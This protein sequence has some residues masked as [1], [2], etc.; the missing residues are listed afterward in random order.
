M[1]DKER[2]QP[3]KPPAELFLTSMRILAPVFYV[4]M[5]TIGMRPAETGGILTS[6]SH[7]YVITGFVFDSHG[8]RTGTTYQPDTRYLNQFLVGRDSEYVGTVHSHP[9]DFLEP[10]PQDQRAAWSNLTSPGNPHLQAFLMPIVQTIPDTGR[11]EIIPFI[12]TCHPRGM[13]EVIVRKVP[14]QIL[15]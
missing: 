11:F 8:S 15:G 2:R 12:A 1:D 3:K 4:I 5:E 6:C 9:E 10:S 13:G 7:D 14:L